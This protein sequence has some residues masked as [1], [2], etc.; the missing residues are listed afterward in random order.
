MSAQRSNNEVQLNRAVTVATHVRTLQVLMARVRKAAE[1]H[2]KPV[3]EVDLDLTAVM[4]AGRICSSN[5]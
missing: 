4:G 5:S 3:V 2:A 1:A